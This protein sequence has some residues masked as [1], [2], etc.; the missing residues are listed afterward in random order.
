M[1]TGTQDGRKRLYLPREA[2]PDRDAPDLPWP[3]L[4]HPRE[5]R[6]PSR[7]S[8]RTGE[9]RN[10]PAVDRIERRTRRRMPRPGRTVTVPVIDP[11]REPP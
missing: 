5:A 7:Q 2:S 8:V 9:R 1:P 6:P 10:V 4:L 11:E 3:R